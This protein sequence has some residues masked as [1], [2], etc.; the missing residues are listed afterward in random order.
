MHN[1]HQVTAIAY[2]AMTL[3]RSETIS[4]PG[5][6]HRPWHAKV[7]RQCYQYQSNIGHIKQVIRFRTEQV[8]KPLITEKLYPRFI[9][10]IT[11]SSSKSP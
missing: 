1:T 5:T 2:Q 11:K 3:P 9:K 10:Q 4:A 6:M 7:S 8:I